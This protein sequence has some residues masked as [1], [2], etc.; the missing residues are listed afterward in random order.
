LL[1]QT[2]NKNIRLSLLR[3]YA[4]NVP[5]YLQFQQYFRSLQPKLLVAWGD[6]DIVFVPP[7]TKALRRDLPSAEVHFTEV[8]HVLLET[9]LLELR[10][11]VLDF[12]SRSLLWTE[13]LYTE[14]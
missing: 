4:N 11:L 8:G 1:N 14:L 3:D 6:K 12:L 2:G 13:Q 5:L 10:D 7:D 9:N